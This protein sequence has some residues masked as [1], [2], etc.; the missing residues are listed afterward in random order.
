MSGW[1]NGIGLA[2]MA[3]AAAA[4]I[5]GDAFAG[6]P[7]RPFAPT[8]QKF[9]L[10][11]DMLAPADL[12]CD[13]D[14]PGVRV[15]QMRDIAGKPVLRLTGNARDAQITCWRP[16]GSRYVTDA[17]RE[18]FYNTAEPLRATVTFSRDRDAMTVVLTRGDDINDIVEVV[19]RSFRRVAAGTETM[20]SSLSSLGG[21]NDGAKDA[22]RLSG[23]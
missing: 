8:G 6:D 16:D 20:D 1:M 2:L 23:D 13:A 7:S 5:A 11:F 10:G 19:P 22:P 21:M 9:Y 15:K 18:Q 17:N 14:G 12:T 3:A 4:M